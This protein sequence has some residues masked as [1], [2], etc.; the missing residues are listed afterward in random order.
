MHLANRKIFSWAG[1]A[2]GIDFAVDRKVDAFTDYV[3]AEIIN[4]CFER[5]DLANGGTFLFEV[6]NHT[7]TDADFIDF[8]AVHVA[9][10]HLTKPARSN[11]DFSVPRFR[12]V[13]NHKMIGE[14][15]FHSSTRMFPAENL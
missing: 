7:N 12:S 3:F 9:P 10:L 2:S 4:E 1:R 14:P 6:A 11:L 15:V 8:F 13:P 5:S